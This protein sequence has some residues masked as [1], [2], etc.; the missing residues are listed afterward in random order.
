MIDSARKK[1]HAT[2]RLLSEMETHLA[3]LRKTW[4][5][6]VVSRGALKGRASE[7]S[8]CGMEKTGGRGGCFNESRIADCGEDPGVRVPWDVVIDRPRGRSKS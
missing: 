2:I 7:K 8:A 5:S 6:E 1:M 3:S 4:L